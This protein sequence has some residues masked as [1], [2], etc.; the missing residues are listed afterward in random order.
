MPPLKMMLLILLLLLLPLATCDADGQAIP[1][2]GVPSAVN[3]RVRPL[4]G[5]DKERG[6]SVAKRCPGPK[7][8]GSGE[9]EVCCESSDC[10]CKLLHS[11]P[12]SRLVCVCP[13]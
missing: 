4:L 1:V 8:C 3:S 11:Q 5:G 7:S 12:F 2:G 6:R 9:A 13:D 10:Y